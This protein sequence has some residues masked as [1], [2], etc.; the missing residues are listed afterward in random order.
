MT[1][2]SLK[3]AHLFFTTLIV[4]ATG[5]GLGLS[6]VE[7][8]PSHPPRLTCDNTASTPATGT[9]KRVRVP[10]GATCY[11]RGATVLG[12]LH[13]KNPRSVYVIDTEVAHNIKIMGATRDV[14]IGNAGCRLDPHAGNNVMVTKSHNVAICQES[15][16]NNIKVSQNDGRISL[17]HN[18]AGRNISVTKN[19]AYD[20]HPGD[21]THRRIA[22]IRFRFNTAGN[23]N[24]VRNNAGRPVLARGNSPHVS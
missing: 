11:L 17:F 16:D 9:Y 4:T 7:G 23:H 8:A 15:V 5:L 3:R 13:A 21:G 22:A 2:R 1:R 18:K 24:R 19:L 10:A 12:N 14:V 20:A 6:P